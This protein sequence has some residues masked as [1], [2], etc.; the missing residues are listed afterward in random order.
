MKVQGTIVTATAIEQISDSFKKRNLILKTYADTNYPQEVCIEL[1]Q[2]NVDLIKGMVKG[3]E[4][5]VDI[6]LRG[7]R[8]EKEGLPTRWFNTLVGWKV[9]KV[10]GNVGAAPAAAQAAPVQQ[11]A[12]VEDDSNDLPF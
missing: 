10:G 3:D 11:A 1:H 9:S 5:E 12:P 4:V 7:N 8:Y 2:N 6:N